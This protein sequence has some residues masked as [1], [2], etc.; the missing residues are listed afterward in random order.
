MLGNRYS[1]L[2]L[3]RALSDMLVLAEYFLVLGLGKMLSSG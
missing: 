3:G 1:I 2:Q